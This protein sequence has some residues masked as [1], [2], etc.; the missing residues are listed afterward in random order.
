MTQADSR[1][2]QAETVKQAVCKLLNKTDEWYAHLQYETGLTYLKQHLPNDAQRRRKC[3]GSGVFWG[4]WRLQWLVRDENY[5]IYAGGLLWADRI[6]EYKA[7][8][9]AELL[10]DENTA[11][12]RWMAG[13][14]DL[15]SREMKRQ[16]TAETAANGTAYALNK[17]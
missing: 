4:W 16:K 5:L 13:G 15:M 8:H 17:Q 7:M 6:A 11:S 14:F 10:A 9:D 2:Q 1:R 12:G 3:E